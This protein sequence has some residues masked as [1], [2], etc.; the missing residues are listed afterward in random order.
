MNAPTP[1]PAY[2][3]SSS[4]ARTAKVLSILLGLFCCRVAGQLV[5]ALF[6]VPWLPPMEEWYSGA[7]AY[8]HLLACQFVIMIVF[9]KVC[10]DLFKANGYFSERH[11][12]L[13]KPMMRFGLLYLFTMVLR[14]TIRMALYGAERWAGGCIPIFFHC[15]LAAFVVVLGWYHT[16]RQKCTEVPRIPT[17]QQS[18]STPLSSI[19][20]WGAVTAAIVAWVGYQ[21]APSTY[22]TV[23]LASDKRYAVRIEKKKAVS[24]D[25]KLTFVEIYRPARTPSLPHAPVVVMVN[26]SRSPLA[27][28]RTNIKARSFAER[29]YL[30][31]AT[32]D[33][34]RSGRSSK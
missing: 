30:V 14:Y 4:S 6:Q 22:G 1:L 16:W 2:C 21:I 5:V 8:P 12:W 7:I 29:G 23:C 26:R 20:A 32:S 17:C 15:V 9:G 34:T 28:L 33:N 13:G 19:F 25:G 18:R 10:R 11:T 31:I 3:E 27:I 24:A